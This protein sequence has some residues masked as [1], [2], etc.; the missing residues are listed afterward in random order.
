MGGGVRG[1]G[2]RAEKG[3]GCPVCGVSQGN[4]AQGLRL[5]DE[6]RQAEAGLGCA[7]VLSDA[8]GCMP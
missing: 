7:D 6:R 2:E 3:P 4:S 5:Q 8:G 1:G